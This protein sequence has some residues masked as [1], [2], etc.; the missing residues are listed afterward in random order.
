MSLLFTTASSFTDIRTIMIADNS[1]CIPQ[2]LGSGSCT[3]DSRLPDYAH[4]Y[5]AV[6]STTS[7]EV[8]NRTFSLW[9]PLVSNTSLV[10]L[11]VISDDDTR[12]NPD[13]FFASLRAQSESIAQVQH[14]QL[15]VI[16]Y[17]L[18]DSDFML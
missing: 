16:N 17:P 1:V 6:G 12:T 14:L 2:P 7:L 3:N 18:R 5:Q 10:V 9:S 13:Q 4:I 11:C 8:V 15:Q